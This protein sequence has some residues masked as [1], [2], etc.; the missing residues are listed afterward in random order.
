[1]SNLDYMDLEILYHAKKSKNGINPEDVSQQDVF[2]PSIWELVDKFASLQE[3]NL[4]TK[5]KEGLF[6][7]TKQGVNTFW[8]MESPLW[9]NLLKLLR[10]KPF[11]D[12]QCAMYLGEPIPAVQQALDMI[13]KKSYVLMSQLRKEEKL[14][15]MYEI[16]PDGIEQLSKSKKGGISFVK[17]GDK[18]VV[19]LDGGEGI[20]YEIIDD[21][22]NPLRMIKTVSK[23]EIKKHK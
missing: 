11:S 1:M 21:L 9:M 12:T 15:K 2:T 16:L 13:R 3:K 17:S 19:E 8:Y 4:L 10:V 14:L 5:N 6:E 20:L 22:V 7:L 18:L 23:E